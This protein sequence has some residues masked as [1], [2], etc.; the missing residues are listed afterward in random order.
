MIPSLSH[1]LAAYTSYSFILARRSSS[2]NTLVVSHILLNLYG[3]WH[4][5]WDRGIVLGGGFRAADNVIVIR[6]AVMT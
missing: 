6:L 2:E 4:I 1:V 5:L 3:Q